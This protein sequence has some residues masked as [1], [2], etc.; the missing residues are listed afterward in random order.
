MTD[1][2]LEAGSITV[3]RFYDVAYA[4]DLARV[5]RLAAAPARI[6]FQPASAKSLSFAVPPVEFSLGQASLSCDSE[7]RVC[8]AVA[9]IYDFGVVALHLRLTVTN[10]SWAGFSGLTQ[11]VAEAGDGAAGVALWGELLSKVR[12]VI[13][14]A[15]DRAGNSELQEEYLIATAY[16]L[17][18]RLS[19]PEFR[20]RVDLI[21]LLTGETR[22]LAPAARAEL[23]AH[24]LSYYENDLV[25]LAWDRAFVLDP[26]RSSDVAD[27]IEVANAQLLELR[28]YDAVLDAELPRMFNRV[29]QS[30]KRLRGIGRG[31]YAR[32]ARELHELVADVTE[33]TERVDNA[34]KVTDDVYL[35]RVY[36][37]ALDLF[38]T[39]NWGDAVD[40]KLRIMR[41]TYTMLY[42]EAST[43]R[44]ELL[45][46]IIILLIAFE[47]VFALVS[48]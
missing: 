35:A 23:L 27:V 19:G 14:P 10:E 33:I 26:D 8:D 21:P 24:T 12:G 22:R 45:E 43:A 13:E 38:R 17:S 28:Y 5:E 11:R 1:L 41:E 4:I 44:A 15:L 9:R 34:L 42:E 7:P 39:K 2:R 6:R 31:R 46:I 3:L 40:R 36:A 29:G 25:V 30:H 47:I 37:A 16:D 32:L 18:P 20:E 48:K